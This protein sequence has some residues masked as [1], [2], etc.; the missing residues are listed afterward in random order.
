MC[1]AKPLGPLRLVWMVELKAY[2]CL[3]YSEWISGSGHFGAQQLF[4]DETCN[5]WSD[6]IC[7]RQSWLDGCSSCSC[8]SSQG[9]RQSHSWS[10]SDHENARTKEGPGASSWRRSWC[11]AANREWAQKPLPWGWKTRKRIQRD[12]A[13]QGFS[14]RM[15]GQLG[16]LRAK[17]QLDHC[18][19]GQTRARLA[20]GAPQSWRVVESTQ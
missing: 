4:W 8:R 20:S 7:D 13:C 18:V 9:P 2:K 11:S 6:C 12:P 1:L 10:S 16:N 14:H 5:N 3:L 17:Q 19:S 15:A